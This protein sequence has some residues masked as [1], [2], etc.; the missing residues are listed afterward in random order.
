V[1]RTIYNA[2]AYQVAWLAVILGAGQGFAWG[3]ALVA[4][5]VVTLHLSLQRRR[6][7]ELKLLGAAAVVG[8]LHE[9][10]LMQLGSVDFAPG[11]WY[12]S[13]PPYWMLGLWLAFA[14]TFHH[15]LRWIMQRPVFAIL[16]GA[17]GGPLA[18]LAGARLGA[19]ALSEHALAAIAVSFGVAMAVLVT[20]Y[21][22]VTLAVAAQATRVGTLATA[23]RLAWWSA[24][25]LPLL[26]TPVPV[27]AD[28]DRAWNFTVSLDGRLIGK[29]SYTLQDR[30]EFQELRSSALFTVK[31]LFFEAYRYEHDARERWRDGCLE[32]LDSR[33]DDNGK[34]R[35]VRATRD[36]ADF[37]IVAGETTR[38]RA[39]CVRSFAYWD[40]D[41]LLRA[42]ALLNPQTGEYLDVQLESLGRGSVEAGSVDRYML[43]AT[44]DDASRL[45][46]I[47][48]WYSPQREWIGLE[49]VTADGRR[50]RYSRER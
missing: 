36:G 35:E 11:G 22:W 21:R 16:A 5:A 20:I 12:A 9:L 44:G 39:P 37:S 31:I 13:W 41:A 3:G 10:A 50:L 47:E 24:L 34:T 7:L 27:R 32:Q 40:L 28:V 8:A 25:L 29:H 17:I 14:T 30:G 48:L 18:Y 26:A 33:T 2:V 4:A 43:R 23:P 49:A 1:A 19:L 45:G 46:P 42:D 15:S 38:E 6:D